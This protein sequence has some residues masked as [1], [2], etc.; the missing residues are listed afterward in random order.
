MC[1]LEHLKE[2]K[3][4]SF[5]TTF[6]TQFLNKIRGSETLER[7]TIVGGYGDWDYVDL[8]EVINTFS[9]LQ[10]LQFHIFGRWAN[11]GDSYLKHFDKLNELSVLM[12]RC[13]SFTSKGF[14][15]LVRKLHK[16]ELMRISNAYSELNI[17]TYEELLEIYSKRNGK[18]TIEHNGILPDS[19]PL[20]GND[21]VIIRRFTPTDPQFHYIEFTN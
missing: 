13:C 2:L 17:E 18:L 14:V 9:N 19:I 20:N 5:N 11:I 12:I 8:M 15:T 7:L 4:E 1:K 16:L 3:L 6:H 21:K 10:F